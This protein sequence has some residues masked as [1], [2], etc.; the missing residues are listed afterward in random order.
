M[1][2]V[3]FFLKA[4]QIHSDKTTATNNLLI[5]EPRTQMSVYKN[6]T[7]YV[8]P[9]TKIQKLKNAIYYIGDE[10]I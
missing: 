4:R 1:L 7:R 10:I 8:D 2:I 3:Q 5:T 6:N 9:Y